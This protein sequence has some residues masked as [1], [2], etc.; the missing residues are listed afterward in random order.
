MPRA[1]G[2]AA[3][4]EFP[5]RRRRQRPRPRPRKWKFRQPLRDLAAAPVVNARALFYQA[6]AMAQSFAPRQAQ[7]TEEAAPAPAGRQQQ[8]SASQNQPFAK[9]RLAA[10][11]NDLQQRPVPN[12]GVRYRIL[13][14]TD[15]NGSTAAATVTVEFTPNDNGILSVK[16]AGRTLFS[17]RVLRLATYTT[18]ALVPSERE[19]T[20]VFSRTAPVAVTGA[21]ALGAQPGNVLHRSEDAD[22]TYVVGEPASQ[23]IHFTISLNPQ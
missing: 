2:G 8:Q 5:E 12:P 20:V 11:A 1:A 17:N 16:S 18:Q 21:K 7:Q 10:A 23:E 9:A 3:A 13:R 6:P 15:T 19:L 4:A 22:G 14:Q